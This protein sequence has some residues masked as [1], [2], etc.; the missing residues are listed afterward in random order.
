MSEKTSRFLLILEVIFIV[1]PLSFLALFISVLDIW[2]MSKY[3]NQYAVVTYGSVFLI[4]LV[5]IASVWQLIIAYLRGGVTNLRRQHSGWWVMALVG[6]LILIA[7]FISNESPHP[8]ELS[9]SDFFRG[10][11]DNFRYGALLLIPLYHVA[12]ERFRRK[13]K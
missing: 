2:S 9:A 12:F 11:F 7:S 1:L 13:V 10:A 4:S 6:V 5:A 3:L 8:S